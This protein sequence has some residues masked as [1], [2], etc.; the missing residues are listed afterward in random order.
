MKYMVVLKI[1]IM[2]NQ[3]IKPVLSFALVLFGCIN[4]L[5]EEDIEEFNHGNIKEEM[6]NHQSD[7]VNR[8]ANMYIWGVA[9][10]LDHNYFTV[11]FLTGMNPDFEKRVKGSLLLELPETIIWVEISDIVYQYLINHKGDLYYPNVVLIDRALN[12]VYGGV[13]D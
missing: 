9:V 7:E 4:P 10:G 13:K 12:E 2:I 6:M 1:R 8:L 3:H 11:D 5:Y